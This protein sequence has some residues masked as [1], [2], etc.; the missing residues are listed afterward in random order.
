[1]IHPSFV[2]C[3]A[4]RSPRCP[5]LCRGRAPKSSV[6]KRFDKCPKCVFSTLAYGTPQTVLLNSVFTPTTLRGWNMLL[7]FQ[8]QD[9]S[10]WQTRLEMK[11]SHEVKLRQLISPSRVGSFE[12]M[13]SPWPAACF[14]PFATTEF[15][16][17][18]TTFSFSGSTTVCRP[19]AAT[20][21]WTESS[22]RFSSLCC[23]ARRFLKDLVFV[24]PLLIPF[25]IPF[26]I[27]LEAIFVLT[28]T[29]ENDFLIPRLVLSSLCSVG[30]GVFGVAGGS[31][32]SAWDENWWISMLSNFSFAS[33]YLGP[34]N[35]Y[36]AL[37][38]KVPHFFLCVVPTQRHQSLLHPL[39][40]KF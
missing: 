4:P 16:L 20:V 29:V 39:A 24:I 34:D 15:P 26:A 37:V 3:S 30:W 23:P 25:A 14:P 22:G 27:S 35:G 32:T 7:I 28:D 12:R 10:I 40:L 17:V 21:G 36:V 38:Q 18:T 31:W 19:L 13:T 8:F 11:L 5:S 6:C 1:M 9:K 2:P 33:E